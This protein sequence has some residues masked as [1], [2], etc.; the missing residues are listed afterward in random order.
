MTN[1]GRRWRYDKQLEKVVEIGTPEDPR[2]FHYVQDD[3]IPPTVS[4]A[5]D[6]GKV[7]TSRSQLYQH[8]RENG[9]ECTGGDHFTGRGVMDWHYKAD[10]ADIRRDAEIALNQLRWGMAPVSEREKEL[11]CQE[12]RTYQ[13][14][15]Q[16]Q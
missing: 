3:T 2:S 9:F 6:E 11:C 1:R 16:R 10:P 8:Y 4:H 13:E 12:E 7:F 15:K 14:Y 5:T